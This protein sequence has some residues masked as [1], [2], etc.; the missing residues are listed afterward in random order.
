MIA[1]IAPFRIRTN[2]HGFYPPHD[3]KH[4]HGVD[5]IMQARRLFHVKCLFAK[6]ENAVEVAKRSE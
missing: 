4:Y 2:A 5:K 1:N 3:M 6:T